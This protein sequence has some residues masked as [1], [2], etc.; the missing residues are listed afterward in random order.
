MKFNFS[1]INQTKFIYHS[2]APLRGFH[3]AISEGLTNIKDKF[4]ACFL[5]FKL[6]SYFLDIIKVKDCL[7]EMQDVAKNILFLALQVKVLARCFHLIKRL[8]IRLFMLLRWS[9]ASFPMIFFYSIYLFGGRLKRAFGDIG[10]R[11]R[12]PLLYLRNFLVFCLFS[13]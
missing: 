10:F 8:T 11:I 6:E 3:Y 9:I 13:P 1:K 5:P 12:C 4:S 7:E 2:N